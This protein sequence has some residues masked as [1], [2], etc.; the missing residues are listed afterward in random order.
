MHTSRWAL[1][2]D[3]ANSDVSRIE[4]KFI[5]LSFKKTPHPLVAKLRG[6]E[7]D[8]TRYHPFSLHDMASSLHWSD[9]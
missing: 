4:P 5:Y 9:A 7:F 6:E 1:E 3:V 2:P 8:L